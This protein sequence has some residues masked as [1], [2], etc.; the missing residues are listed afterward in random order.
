MGYG[1]NLGWWFAS[2]EIYDHVL[3]LVIHSPRK[4]L[5]WSGKRQ[6]KWHHKND[7]SDLELLFSGTIGSACCRA[8]T[9][10]S[11]EPERSISRLYMKME[12]D[13]FHLRKMSSSMIAKTQI[14]LRCRVFGEEDL[15]NFVWLPLALLLHLFHFCHCLLGECFAL[16]WWLWKPKLFLLRLS[17]R[18]VFRE[19]VVPEVQSCFSW[20]EGAVLE[21]VLLPCCVSVNHPELEKPIKWNYLRKEKAEK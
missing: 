9:V 3:H 7:F 19:L 10:L 15:V 5:V 11:E 13:G 8:P 2:A 6:K 4:Q 14:Y 17:V 16:I 20:R 18:R 1:T 12:C 21:V